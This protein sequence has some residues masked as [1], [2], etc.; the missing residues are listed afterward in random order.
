LQVHECAVE[1]NLE[2]ERT[3]VDRRIFEPRFEPASFHGCA[4][5]L[6]TERAVADR[7]I[8]EPRFE[9]ASSRVCS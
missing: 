8:F 4:V 5:E 3:V 2:S 6:E 1:L 9:L 7:R